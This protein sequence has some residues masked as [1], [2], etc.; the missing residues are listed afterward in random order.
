MKT[1]IELDKNNFIFLSEMECIGNAGPPFNILFI[2]KI[3]L[4][5]ISKSE[6][7]EKLKELKE[8]EKDVR[9]YDSFGDEDKKPDK[10]LD[11]KE[12][13]KV[14]ESL[15]YTHK[16]QELMK[17]DT[18]FGS[19]HYFRGNVLIKNKYLIVSIDIIIF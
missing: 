17:Y 1:I 16:K 3:W 13:K 11:E 18:S 7:A 6:K 10:K 14:I 9:Y 8:R 5:E 12:I 15:K 2:D 19:H 4:K